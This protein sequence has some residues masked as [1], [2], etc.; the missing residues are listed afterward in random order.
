MNRHPTTFLAHIWIA[1]ALLSGCSTPISQPLDGSQAIKSMGFPDIAVPAQTYMDVKNSMV[2]GGGAQWTGRLLAKTDLSPT[3]VSAYLKSQMVA[4]GWTL[5][6]S[7]QAD[8]SSLLFCNALK[9]MS[10]DVTPSG[11]LSSGSEL[12]Y[13]ASVF[14]KGAS[15]QPGEWLCR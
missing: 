9:L 3:E 13:V 8:N 11:F 15:T 1:F 5:L 7:V 2:I 14:N 12:T 4:K 6:S 10:I